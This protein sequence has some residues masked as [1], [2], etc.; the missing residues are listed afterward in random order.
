MAKI[1]GGALAA[2]TLKQHGIDHLF[3]LV[4]GHIYP[5]LEGCAAEGIRFVDVRHEESGAHMAEGWALATGRTGACIGTAGPGFTNMLT[6][7]ANAYSGAYPVLAIAGHASTHE[8][9]TRALQ[10]FNQLDMVKPTTKFARTVYQAGRI[11]EIFDVALSQARTGRPGPAYVETP[12]EQ[13][14]KEVEEDAVATPLSGGAPPLGAG[15]NP[16]ELDRAIEL[17]DKAEKPLIIAGGGVFWSQG[18]DKLRALAERAD[19]PLFTRSAGRGCVPD[20]H[21]LVIAPGTVGPVAHGAMAQADLIILLGTRFGFTFDAKLAPAA[22]KMIRVDI[23]PAAFHNGRASDVSIVGDVGVVLGQLGDGVRQVKHTQWIEELQATAKGF[24]DA[25]AVGRLSDA[26]PIHPLRLFGEI[27]NFVDSETVVCVDGGDVCG[28]G[29][30]MLPAPGPGQFL[31]LLSSNFGC[32][33]VGVPYGIAAKLAHP[34]KKV[35]VTTG[36]GSFGFTAMEMETAVRHGIP[37]VTVVGNDQGWGNIKHPFKAMRGEALP[38]CDLPP[39]RYDKIVEAMGGH[40]ELVVKPK[41]I[42]PAIQ[43]AID[44]G[45]PACV[46]V[47]TDPEVGIGSSY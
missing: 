31:S 9:D 1:S 16:A 30:L 14:F 20:D 25:M 36:D 2:R 28:W 40:G 8:S 3:G 47:M 42:A 27:A 6:G 15:A 41:D 37:I 23:D 7:I 34:D 32:L 39:T 45:L 11:P 35:I 26:D 22:T 12:M 18:Q 13:L 24:D 33:G 19:I 4:G 46:N 38:S 5:I 10:D 17:I 29:N 43:R 44:S 21:P